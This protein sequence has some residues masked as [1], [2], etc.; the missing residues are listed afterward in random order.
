VL[1]SPFANRGTRQSQRRRPTFVVNRVNAGCERHRTH[2]WSTVSFDSPAVGWEHRLRV[3]DLDM[4]TLRVVERWICMNCS[5]AA[6]SSV[7]QSLIGVR[8]T[9][10]PKFWYA[11]AISL[12]IPH[13]LFCTRKRVVVN[14]GGPCGALGGEAPPCGCRAAALTAPASSLSGIGWLPLDLGPTREIR[15][16]ITIRRGDWGTVDL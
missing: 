15:S 16:N 9:L 11:A 5:T 7:N 12:A 1:A 8:R 4:K 2:N 14:L 6:R 3:R 10:R 13:P